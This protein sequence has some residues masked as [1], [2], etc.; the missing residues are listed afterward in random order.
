DGLREGDTVLAFLTAS[1]DEAVSGPSGVGDWTLEEE[2]FLSPMAVRLYSH[3]AD[4][5]EAGK[6]LTV[7]SG[8]RVKWDLTV[9]AYRGTGDDPVEVLAAK[10]VRNTASHTSPTVQVNGADRMGMT[11][12]S[13]RG[14]TTTEW[15]APDGPSVLSTQVG[16]GGG[17]VS[18]LLVAE[19]APAGTYGGLTAETNAPTSR[20]ASMTVVLAPQAAG[21]NGGNEPPEAALDVSCTQLECSFDGAGSQDPDGS[22]ASYEWDFGDGDTAS[23][24]SVEHTY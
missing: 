21:G 4:G 24:A 9:V 17:R 13:D 22:I 14:G 10:A 6:T 18:S 12:W 20:A 2:T 15:T 8:N 23:G 11:Y 1:R 7:S 3:V 19:P 5:S 16:S